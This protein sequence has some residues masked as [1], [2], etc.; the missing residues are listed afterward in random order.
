MMQEKIALLGAA[1]A[2]QEEESNNYSGAIIGAS[3]AV[4]GT[5][6]AIFAA[7][8]CNKNNDDFERQ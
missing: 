6:A 5:A 3:V 7:R 4:L 1:Q 2:P 8:R